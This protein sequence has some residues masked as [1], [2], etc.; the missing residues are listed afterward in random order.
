MALILGWR[1][2][3][4]VLATILDQNRRE[5]VGKLVKEFQSENTGNPPKMIHKKDTP[6]LV[7]GGTVFLT[8]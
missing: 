6:S 4:M 1:L 8:G 2:L 3:L 5:D 7:A